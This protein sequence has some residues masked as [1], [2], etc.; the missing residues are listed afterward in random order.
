MSLAPASKTWAQKGNS[1]K[2]DKD[3]KKEIVVNQ[4]LCWA[5]TIGSITFD[6]PRSIGQFGYLDR[7]K[8]SSVPRLSSEN[9]CLAADHRAL[10]AKSSYKVEH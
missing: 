3:L 6:H 7:N 1:Y 5:G 2:N 9:V 8:A 4:D 10:I